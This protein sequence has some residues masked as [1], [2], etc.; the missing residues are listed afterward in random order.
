MN[1]YNQNSNYKNSNYKNNN[2]QNS[3]Y[4]NNNYAKSDSSNKWDSQKTTKTPYYNNINKYAPRES[5]HNDYGNEYFP[6]DPLLEDVPTTSNLQDASKSFIID[7]DN[8]FKFNSGYKLA[9]ENATIIFGIC[10]R[11]IDSNDELIR[12]IAWQ[13]VRSSNSVMANLCESNNSKTNKMLLQK[14]YVSY[15][16]LNETLGHLEFLL[17]CDYITQDEY[18][19]IYNRYIHITRILR[20]SINTINAKDS[21]E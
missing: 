6:E 2:Y 4:R 15:G 19:D 16:E 18:S 1:N 10:R 5:A 21:H 17:R 20:K 12:P 13:I 7:S 3:N 14:I 8:I 9:M 11:L